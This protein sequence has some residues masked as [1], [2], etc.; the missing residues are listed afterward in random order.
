MGFRRFQNFQIGA[1]SASR[2]NEMQAA[3]ERLQAHVEGRP[4]PLEPI[5]DR[6]LARVTGTGTVAGFEGC[7]GAIRAVSYPFTEVFLRIPTPGAI[8]ASTCIGYEIPADAIENRR[9]A[10]LVVFE[11]RPSL[12]VGTVVVAHLAPMSADDTADDKQQVYVAQVGGGSD[13]GMRTCTMTGLLDDGR[14]KGTLN[15]GG[16]DIEIEN[17]YESQDYYGAGDATLECA[18]L[19]TGIRLPIGSDVWAM[20]VTG[21]GDRDGKWI[22]MTPVPFGVECTCGEDG[23]ALQVQM[24]QDKGSAA[25][26]LIASITKA[27]T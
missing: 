1:L 25:A 8:V 9:Q 21:G 26:G 3:I 17:L 4:S 13:G 10:H 12:A 2:L 18:S 24:R 14:Y 23:R 20:R 15:G 11:D 5:R 27:I 7:D 22:T 6:I 16:G 19:V